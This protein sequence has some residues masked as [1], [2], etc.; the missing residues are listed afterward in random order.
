MYTRNTEYESSPKWLH[1]TLSPNQPVR[2]LSLLNKSHLSSPGLAFIPSPRVGNLCFN[3]RDTL[4]WSYHQQETPVVLR[5]DTFVVALFV[6]LMGDPCGSLTIT[7]TSRNQ[8]AVHL[9]PDC[10]HLDLVIQYSHCLAPAFCCPTTVQQ[11]WLNDI[12]IVT[13]ETRQHLVWSRFP[14]ILYLGTTN[15]MVTQEDS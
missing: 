7:W 10:H 5:Q 6:L 8:L 3:Q 14:C 15:G 9:L 12:H 11:S 1:Y 2:C 4:G 13:F